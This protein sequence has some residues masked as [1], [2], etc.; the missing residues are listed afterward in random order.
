[1]TRNRDAPLT[2]IDCLLLKQCAVTGRY[3]NKRCAPYVSTSSSRFQFPVFPRVTRTIRP[4]TNLPVLTYAM[5]RGHSEGDLVKMGI[6]DQP[7]A[8]QRQSARGGEGRS[9]AVRK[10]WIFQAAQ[11]RQLLLGLVC[12]ADPTK[13]PKAGDR[14]MFEGFEYIEGQPHVRPSVPGGVG[15]T[16]VE[17]RVSFLICVH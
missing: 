12:R 2:H 6:V 11:L 17:L 8:G 1:M 14:E 16:V 10:E 5:L 13:P 7:T 4:P 9:A 3:I 15:F